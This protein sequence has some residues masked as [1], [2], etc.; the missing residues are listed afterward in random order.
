MNLLHINMLVQS[1]TVGLL[2]LHGIFAAPLLVEKQAMVENT[3][4]DRFHVVLNPFVQVGWIQVAV[5]M[6]SVTFGWNIQ[7]DLSHFEDSRANLKSVG[8]AVVRHVKDNATVQWASDTIRRL[9]DRMVHTQMDFSRSIGEAK[10][11]QRRSVLNTLASLFLGY[12][13]FA[14]S[15]QIDRLAK[16]SIHIETNLRLAE[17]GL[18][19]LDDNIRRVA[20]YD[21]QHNAVETVLLRA[22]AE[23][24]DLCDHL[25]SKAKFVASLASGELD[26]TLLPMNAF[27][28]LSRDLQ[29]ATASRG[30]EL[31][32][33]DQ[34]AKYQFE[35][36]V[37]QGWLSIT[38][39][40]PVVRP[41]V[42]RLPLFQP[43]GALMKRGNESYTLGQ[44]SSLSA[45]GVNGSYF[46][47]IDP[48]TLLGCQL[49][50][51]TYLCPHV[52]SLYRKPVSCS[53][54]RLLRQVE[55][56]VSH[57]VLER[58]PVDAIVL[59]SLNNTVTA[60]GQGNHQGMVES[61]GNGT[62][63]MSHF[64]SFSMN[65]SCSYQDGFCVHIP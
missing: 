55:L 59:S 39:H 1:L 29:N 18:R 34:L 10:G 42:P 30:L 48:A 56:I 20:K 36:G 31:I 23:V 28:A 9:S 52:R 17:A 54:A 26:L 37:S 4:H 13:V 24:L 27:L 57:C 2:V 45:M 33:V 65:S 64:E 8:S 12:E 43:L 15:G 19:T 32:M 5:D 6:V 58:L 40:A 60:V 50:K 16:E 35:Y 21:Q 49:I 7:T 41:S 62:R 46:L 47:E 63:R 3:T 51:S 22:Q 25:G 61:C 11:R 53:H 14:Q 44:D 38:M